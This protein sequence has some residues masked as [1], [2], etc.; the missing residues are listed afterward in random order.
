MR[1]KPKHL[2]Q[3][4][5]SFT[6]SG[7]TVQNSEKSLTPSETKSLKEHE[8]V[9]AAHLSAFFAV[10]NALLEIQRR[11]LYRGEFATFEEYCRL[12]WDM[13]RSYA[14]RLLK[15]AEV[16]AALSPIGD[17]PLPENEAQVRPLI[18][19]PPEKIALAWGEVVRSTHAGKVSASIVRNVVKQLEHGNAEKDLETQWEHDLRKYL[20]E[21]IA[22]VQKKELETALDNVDRARIRLDIEIQKKNLKREES[23]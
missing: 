6:P 12:R 1:A 5:H 4:N 15:A 14:Y 8:S 16:C 3:E 9:I 10:G 23:D 22:A 7:R 20:S 13:S 19:L 11:K 21:A 18:H 17:I 2:S